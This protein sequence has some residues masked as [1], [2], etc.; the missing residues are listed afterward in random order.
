MKCLVGNHIEE[1]LDEGGKWMHIDMAS[2]SFSGARATG[3]ELLNLFY[4]L[5]TV[6]C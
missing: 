6:D 3:A 1:Y 2:P 5:L 4:S